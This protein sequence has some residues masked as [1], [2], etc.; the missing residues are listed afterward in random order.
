MPSWHDFQPFIVTGLALGG[1]YA[2]SGAGMVVLYRTT[3]V[4]NL[5]FGAVGAMS[6]LIAWDLINNSLW[7]EWP[8]YGVAVAIAAG[9]TLAYG[10]VIG[11]ALARRDALVKATATL[12]LALILLGTMSWI[13]SDKARSQVLPTSTHA[14]DVGQVAVT[15]TQV[16]AFALGVV[17]VFGT[18]IFLKYTKLGTAMRG[19]ANDR[20]ITATL[21]VPVRWV[22]AQAWL[23]SGILSGIS[24]LLLSDLV[25][26]DAV[27]LTFLVISSLAAALIARLRSLTV[28]FFAALAVGL[29][30]A[31][32]TP[33]NSISEYRNMAPFVIATLALLVISR[34]RE[35]SFTG[36]G[37]GNGRG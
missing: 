28:T 18:G 8:A 7:P 6:A 20:E 13:W 11:P 25:G 10:V 12:G 32:A 14:F 22:E 15:W 1:V 31:M 36:T 27:S 35:I 5:A 29:V 2:L 16:I 37:L 17:V 3:G 23:V 19:L 26:L 30:S 21:G 9:I 24:G 34:K 33:I 4:L